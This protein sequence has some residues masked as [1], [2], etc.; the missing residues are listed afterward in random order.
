MKLTVKQRPVNGFLG[1][2]KQVNFML[3]Y[4]SASYELAVEQLR[5]RIITIRFS[6]AYGYENILGVYYSLETL[7]MLFDGHFYPVASAFENE[8]EITQSWKR[9]ELP[10]YHS[11]DFVL[12]TENR[13][14]AFDSVLN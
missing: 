13:L 12:G 10:S 6:D 8:T 5:E 1:G 9:R 7:L 4:N 14:L 11:A 2:P 3:F